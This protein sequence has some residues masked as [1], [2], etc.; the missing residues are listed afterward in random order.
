[1]QAKKNKNVDSS[2]DLSYCAFCGNQILE[3]NVFHNGVCRA[4]CDRKLRG[5]AN[6]LAAM[7]HDCHKAN[8]QASG[9]SEHQENKR[10]LNKALWTKLSNPVF[11]ADRSIEAMGNERLLL[12]LARLWLGGYAVDKFDKATYEMLVGN[13]WCEFND[14]LYTAL[15]RKEIEGNTI[16]V[17]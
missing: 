6:K 14:K 2:P 13:G 7:I 15:Q 8:A 3:P 17:V 16:D 5:F 12:P 11:S 10:G 1:M 4:G 9:D